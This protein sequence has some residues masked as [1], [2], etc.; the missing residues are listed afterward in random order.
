MTWTFVRK[1]LRLRDSRNGWSKKWS[2]S[3]AQCFAWFVRSTVR[4][5]L[6][7]SVLELRQQLHAE[8]SSRDTWCNVLVGMLC[9][10][11]KT[12]CFFLCYQQDGSKTRVLASLDVCFS[13]T[14]SSPTES[15]NAPF[16]VGWWELKY[17]QLL[18]PCFKH[19]AIS[20]RQNWKVKNV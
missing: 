10:G 12:S 5:R 4:L 11:L 7:Q 18:L 6:R 15:N 8:I 13:P 9:G 3:L 20:Y 14:F 2:S 1:T 17:S 19:A 16:P